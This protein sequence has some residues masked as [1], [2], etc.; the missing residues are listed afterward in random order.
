MVRQ[1]HVDLSPSKETYQAVKADV[2]PRSAIKEL[3]DNAIDNRTR[4]EAQEDSLRV[5]IT[6]LTPE[7]SP[8]DTEELVIW[9]NSGGLKEKNLKLFFRPW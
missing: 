2:N 3:V 5:K 7:E 6:H 1:K 4:N 9:D 8:N